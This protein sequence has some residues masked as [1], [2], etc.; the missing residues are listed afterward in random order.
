MQLRSRAVSFPEYLKLKS[1]SVQID[2]RNRKVTYPNLKAY[3]Y[4]DA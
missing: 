3:A 4:A 1:I 2:I